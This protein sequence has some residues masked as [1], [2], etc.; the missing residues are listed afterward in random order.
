MDTKGF[1]IGTFS[2]LP[3][4]LLLI[5][6]KER[7]AV[8][9][10]EKS[11]RA[12]LRSKKRR[13]EKDDSG[14]GLESEGQNEVTYALSVVKEALEDTPQLEARLIHAQNGHLIT[15]IDKDSGQILKRYRIK[16]ILSGRVFADSQ[17]F[18]TLFDMTV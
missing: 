7:P 16:D 18:G 13:E 17:V 11:T 10:I 14:K 4:S 6:E 5:N 8:R 3:A 9:P 2:F 15:I 1:D 12:R